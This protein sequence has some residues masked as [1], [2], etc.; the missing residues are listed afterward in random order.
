MSFLDTDLY[1]FT[2]GQLVF[3]NWPEA[4]VEYEFINR[5]GR[6]F[7]SKFVIALQ[8]SIKYGMDNSAGAPL[9]HEIEYLA[10]LGYFK[11]TYLE[12]LSSYRWNLKELDISFQNGNLAIKIKGPWRRTI[13]WEVPLMARI[14]ELYHNPYYDRYTTT[15]KPVSTS[16]AMKDKLDT[17]IEKLKEKINVLESNDIKWCEF[18][19]RRRF[20]FSHHYRVLST[21]KESKCKNFL[22]T[23]NVH[24]AKRFDM[25]VVGTMA[26][27][28]PMAM[29]AIWPTG[30]SNAVWADAWLGLY[31]QQL[32]TILPDTLTTDCF[33]KNIGATIRFFKSIRQDSGD[34][35]VFI[36]KIIK[37][38]KNNKLSP[39][40]TI[41]C[42]D[43]LNVDKLKNIV[44]IWRHKANIIGA[45]GTNLTNDI[46]GVKPLNMVIKMT[47]ANFG[48]GWKNVV[49]L[50]DEPG[51]ETG[52][53]ETIER[54]R[55]YL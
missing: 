29:Q 18:G 2:M 1:K 50:S 26:H 3:Y 27:E 32:N 10:S 47:K 15:E 39:L 14:A 20:S 35:D 54:V 9:K 43:N 7:D 49:K 22:G 23:S 51:K 5:D 53:K 46:E 6:P 52:D 21:I 19:T 41:I 25:P 37:Y 17:S 28:G 16:W 13:Y 8:D 11:P 24:F 38:Y 42:S 40:P 55:S 4:E 44:E 48:Y 36:E 30:Y 12:W 45:I 34:P 31:G 33:L